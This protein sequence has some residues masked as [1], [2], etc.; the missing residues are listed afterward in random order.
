[1][2]HLIDMNMM[3][4]DPSPQHRFFVTMNLL[5]LITL[6]I[7]IRRTF[8]MSYIKYLKTYINKYSDNIAPDN[9]INEYSDEILL[10]PQERIKYKQFGKIP[11]IKINKFANSIILIYATIYIISNNTNYFSDA[12]TINL[13][14]LSFVYFSNLFI[15][16][17]NILFCSC[18]ILFLCKLTILIFGLANIIY[19]YMFIYNVIFYPNLIKIEYDNVQIIIEI[20]VSI[21][22]I[23]LTM[24]NYSNIKK[25]NTLDFNAV[26]YGSVI[27]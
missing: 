16:S 27:V 20:V 25:L 1:M 9:F 8:L 14:N 17:S 12:Y 26:N 23:S 6:M 15:Q 3:Y 4:L 21:I 18:L 2:D 7:F 13:S 11:Y 19:V 10:T 22:M 5:L 24:Y